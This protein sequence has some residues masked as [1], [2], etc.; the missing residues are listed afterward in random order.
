MVDFLRMFAFI[1]CQPRTYHLVYVRFLDE[2]CKCKKDEHDMNVKKVICVL[3]ITYDCSD[4]NSNIFMLDYSG[5][6]PFIYTH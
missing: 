3:P 4:L 2:K 1:V 5:Y 6:E